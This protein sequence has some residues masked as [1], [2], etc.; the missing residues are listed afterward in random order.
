MNA[1]RILDLSEHKAVRYRKMAFIMA[2]GIL[3]TERRRGHGTALVNHMW[4]WLA[5]RKIQLVSLNVL[6]RNESAQMFYR[7]AGFETVSLGM[8]RVPQEVNDEP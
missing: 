7:S 8:Q 3:E 1:L 2:I 6:A 5:E 4:D